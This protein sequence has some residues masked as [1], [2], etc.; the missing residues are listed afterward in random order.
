MKH[1]TEINVILTSNKSV[2]FAESLVL[3]VSV[4]VQLNLI[5][6]WTMNPCWTQARSSG[7][8]DYSKITVKQDDTQ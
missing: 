3:S 1:D 8:I 5:L 7:D 6:C 4:S 2:L